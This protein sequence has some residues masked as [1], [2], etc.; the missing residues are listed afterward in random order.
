ML[1]RL[2]SIVCALGLAVAPAAHAAGGHYGFDGGTRTQQAQVRAALNA[3][4]F[5]W[6]VVPGPVV[7]HIAADVVS[8]A[9]PAPNEI[10]L[11]ASLLDSGRFS[12]GVVQHEYAHLV[13][14][15]VLTDPMR[16]ELAPLLGGT[17]W[18]GAAAEHDQLGSERFADLV[19]WAYW[20]SPDNVLKP[21]GA[22]ASA[23]GFRNALASLLTVRT[24]QRVSGTT[25]RR[26]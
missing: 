8:S 14:F 25:V 21:A 10:W 17:S 18:W 20:P 19:A 15:T 13:D 5:D 7:V 9:A 16:T 22:A 4:A 11:D 3:S 6:N 26:G 12:W 1:P 24:L 23:A 2:A